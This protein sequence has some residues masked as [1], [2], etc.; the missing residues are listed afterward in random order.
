MEI[1]QQDISFC[2][3]SDWWNVH[4]TGLSIQY[5]RSADNCTYIEYWILKNWYRSD[6]KVDVEIVS[7]FDN[8]KLIFM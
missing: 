3:N 6:E 8:R 4:F 1:I 2:G 5:Y 7:C